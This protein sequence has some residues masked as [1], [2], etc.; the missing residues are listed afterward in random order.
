MI[1][2]ISINCFIHETLSYII[3]QNYFKLYM[4]VINVY[5]DKKILLLIILLLLN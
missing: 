4:I 1:F 5:S 2:Y 3:L